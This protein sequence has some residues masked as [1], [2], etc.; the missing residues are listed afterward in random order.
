MEQRVE[1]IK[2][3]TKPITFNCK[4]RLAKA[5]ISHGTT[6][7]SVV[8]LLYIDIVPCMYF[9]HYINMIHFLVQH[10]HTGES[11]KTVQNQNNF[12]NVSKTS[13]VVGHSQDMV[14]GATAPLSVFSP[15]HFSWTVL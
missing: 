10:N 7:G 3:S 1:R 4:A 15:E 12:S 5:K 9:F 11:K 6:L 14:N 13:S 2:L 8:V